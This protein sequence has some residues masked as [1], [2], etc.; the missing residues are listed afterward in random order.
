MVNCIVGNWTLRGGLRY[1]EL[2]FAA[3]KRFMRTVELCFE[4]VVAIWRRH[5]YFFFKI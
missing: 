5:L 4:K 1:I 3:E 2:G